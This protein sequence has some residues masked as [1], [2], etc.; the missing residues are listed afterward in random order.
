MATAI[1]FDG[2]ARF[3]F[4]GMLFAISVAVV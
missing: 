4:A 1:D 2:L 3:V